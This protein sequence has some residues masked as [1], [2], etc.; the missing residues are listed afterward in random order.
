MDTTRVTGL[1]KADLSETIQ[2]YKDLGKFCSSSAKKKK[3][4]IDL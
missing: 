2:L 3:E 4:E 1:K